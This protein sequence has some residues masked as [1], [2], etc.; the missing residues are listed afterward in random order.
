[1]KRPMSQSPVPPLPLCPGCGAVG[2]REY[3]DYAGDAG[4]TISLGLFSTVKLS[5]LICLQCGYTEIRP[6]P[7]ALKTLRASANRQ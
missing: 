5:A 2:T 4:F 3:F 6:E 1:M 7:G